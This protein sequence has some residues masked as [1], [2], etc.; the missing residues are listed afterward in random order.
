MAIYRLDAS[1]SSASFSARHTMMARVR[2]ELGIVSGTLSFD[3]ANPSAASVE[4]ELD[5]ASIATR[6][7]KRDEHLRSADFLDIAQFPTLTFKSTRVETKD[8]KAGKVYGDLTI[9]GVTRPVVI[10][11][12]NLGEQ[13]SPWGNKVVGFSGS[14]KVNREDWGLTWNVALEAGGWLVSKEIEINLDVEALPVTEAAA[15]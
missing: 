3:P 1:H 5:A 14:T 8:G 9:R 6:D 7:E 2:G 4:V 11:A 10:D 12:V 13:T 15:D